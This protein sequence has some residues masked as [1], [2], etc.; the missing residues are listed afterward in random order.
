M[1]NRRRADHGQ[2]RNDL[3]KGIE[4]GSRECIDARHQQAMD[5]VQATLTDSGEQR[6]VFAGAV[7]QDSQLLV[8]QL[9][10]L[11]LRQVGT[12]HQS[13][14]GAEQ[15]QYRA[16]LGNDGDCADCR[17]DVDHRCPLVTPHGNKAAFVE[18]VAQ[19]RQRQ[20]CNFQYIH[21][22][23]GSKAHAQGFTAQAIVVG[24]RVLLCESAGNQRLQIAM[25]LACRHVD[26]FGQ[27][28][29]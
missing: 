7:S 21:P 9:D 14:R 20:G 25:H 3:A 28:R 10:R 22:A 1:E 26:M 6:L 13:G 24:G 29:Q 19:L 8:T 23:Q 18:R 15:G 16:D 27:A 4:H 12:E 11:A 2:Y 17:L 5:M